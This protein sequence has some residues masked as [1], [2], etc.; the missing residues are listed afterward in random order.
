MGPLRQPAGLPWSGAPLRRSK[1]M[2]HVVVCGAGGFIGSHLVK[3]LKAE[4]HWV[5]GVDRKKPEFG[6]TAADEFLVLDLRD[7]EHA[8]RAVAPDGLEKIAEVYQLA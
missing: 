8:R 4:G 1:R 7:M 6:P 5:R 3:R 2:N